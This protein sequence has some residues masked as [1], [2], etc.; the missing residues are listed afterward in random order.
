MGIV[1]LLSC[2]Y[3]YNVYLIVVLL[4]LSSVK[5]KLFGKIWGDVEGDFIGVCRYVEDY[6]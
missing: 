1:G 4:F 5:K 6:L 2:F 3:S